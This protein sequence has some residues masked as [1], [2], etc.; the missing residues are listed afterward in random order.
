VIPG[1]PEWPDGTV[2][3]WAGDP[4]PPT[5]LRVT[6]AYPGRAFGYAF[7]A[8]IFGGLISGFLTFGMAWIAH[9]LLGRGMLNSP[10]PMYAVWPFV[11]IPLWYGAM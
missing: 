5:V 8:G 6:L 10:K 11:S 2:S 3:P 1:K 9:S 4:E 7:L